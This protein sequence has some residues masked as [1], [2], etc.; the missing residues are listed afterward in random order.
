MARI[1]V[2]GVYE[3]D[4]II[5]L[6][7]EPEGLEPG[8]RVVVELEPERAGAAAAAPGEAAAPL[9]RG[10]VGLAQLL[11]DAPEELRRGIWDIVDH[12]ARQLAERIARDERLLG[13]Y[14]AV[15]RL[16][17]G[18]AAARIGPPPLDNDTW[19][20]ILSDF[21]TVLEKAGM[22]E[23]TRPLREVANARQLFPYDY[24]L[25]ALRGDTG[26]L[27]EL[28]ERTGAPRETVLLVFTAMA[29]AVERAVR[30]ALSRGE[31][32]SRSVS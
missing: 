22:F 29:E 25:A 10:R 14:E 18:M 21:L 9:P 2:A 32:A 27:E 15:E 6:D 16:E 4:R 19:L 12:A 30:L 28:A 13:L 3:G 1:R 31:G 23:E 5:R 11:E 26:A 17:P 20:L 24:V 7:E 8:E